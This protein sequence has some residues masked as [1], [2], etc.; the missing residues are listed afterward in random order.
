MTSVPMLL[1]Q[2]IM[3]KLL[4]PSLTMG[5]VDVATIKPEHVAKAPEVPWL[6]PV[7]SQRLLKFFVG[8]YCELTRCNAYH[9]VWV[10]QSFS[11]RRYET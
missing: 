7:D 2:D 1:T 4:K 3:D 11:Q 8:C 10:Y 9:T 6:E 5:V